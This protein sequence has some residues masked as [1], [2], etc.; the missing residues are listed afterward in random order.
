MNIKSHTID[1][2]VDLAVMKAKAASAGSNRLLGRWAAMTTAGI[3]A[4]A[5]A[6]GMSMDDSRVSRCDLPCA[7]PRFMYPPR[8][9]GC[10]AKSAHPA[11]R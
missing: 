11:A 6:S 7:R 1:A 8:S 4:I 10:E 9:A 2:C 5:A 3:A